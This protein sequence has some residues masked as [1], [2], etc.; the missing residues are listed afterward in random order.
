[1]QDISLQI[2]KDMN[3]TVEDSL[4]DFFRPETLENDNTEM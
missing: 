4:Q 1:M 2:K 3:L